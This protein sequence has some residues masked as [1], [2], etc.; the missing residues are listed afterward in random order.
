MR[1]QFL[2]TSNIY[3]R[4]SKS[5]LLRARVSILYYIIHTH[6]LSMRLVPSFVAENKTPK[7]RSPTPPF[8]YSFARS[9]HLVRLVLRLIRVPTS[10]VL[11]SQHTLLSGERS[12]QPA[13]ILSTHPPTVLDD[14]GDYMATFAIP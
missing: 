5:G 12:S 8:W 10:L 14:N 11:L 9:I 13:S 7:P 2:S 6:S 1:F 4:D 3:S